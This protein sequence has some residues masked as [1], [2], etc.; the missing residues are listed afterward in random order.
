MS[1]S[2]FFSLVG[3]FLLV[4]LG[5]GKHLQREMVDFWDLRYQLMSQPQAAAEKI[6][7]KEKRKWSPVKCLL[8][9]SWKVE[10]RCVDICETL[11]VHRDRGSSISRRRFSVKR[12]YHL[13][14]KCSLFS[15][16]ISLPKLESQ[17]K[18]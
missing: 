16:R 9:V 6:C 18:M 17:F 13:S 5:V 12:Y 8:T 7:S 10:G 11:K 15:S 14:K 2:V 3:V 4:T 1:F